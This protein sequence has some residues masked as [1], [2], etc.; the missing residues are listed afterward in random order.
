MN[1]DLRF[2]NKKQ[3]G[4]TLIELLVVIAIIGILS[5]ILMVSFAGIR[6]RNRDS[7]RKSD[8]LEIKTALELYRSDKGFYP[9]TVLPL[10]PPGNFL[11]PTNCGKGVNFT[12][13]GGTIYLKDLP[14]D[15]KSTTTP[16]MYIPVTGSVNARYDLKACLENARDQDSNINSA[17]TACAS[18][19]KTYIITNP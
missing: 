12:D 6:E 3:T 11:F 16:Y 2:K 10:D 15:P 13:A 4:F 17:D 9:D 5:T 8:L 14:C 19:L 7:K 1:L 18:P